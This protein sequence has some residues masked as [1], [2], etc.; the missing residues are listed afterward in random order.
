MATRYISSPGVQISETDR[1]LLVSTELGT[2]VFMTGF[3]AQGPT[4]EVTQIGSVSEYESIFG[5]P[6]N[7]QER[8]LYHSA[9]QVLTQSP[10]RLLITRIPY[11][12]GE[13]DGYASSYSALV[14]PVSATLNGSGTKNNWIATSNYTSSPVAVL[15]YVAAFTDVITGGAGSLGTDYFTSIGITSSTS[16]AY[17][18]NINSLYRNYPTLTVFTSSGESPNITAS[19]SS[20]YVT[21][22]TYEEADAFTILKPSSVILTDAQYEYI[23]SGGL[24]WSDRYTISEVNAYSEIAKGG[25]VVL[26]PSKLA[27][28]SL[29][30][31]YYLAVADNSNNG[32]STNFD[33]ITGIQAANS[34]NG[35]KQFYTDI[36]TSRLNFALSADYRSPKNSIS[37]SIERLPNGFDFG[38]T[39]YNDSLTF[40]LYKIRTSIYGNTVSLDYRIDTPIVGS[41]YANK[42]QNNPL[43]GSPVAFSLDKV[44]EATRG[45]I[46]IHVNPFI[47]SRGT[48]VNENGSP[49]K[50]VRV[51]NSAKNLYS[52]GVFVSNTNDTLNDIGNLPAKV[53]RNLTRL[54]DLD[55]D[56]DI[57]TECGLGTIWAGAK[58]N[59]RSKPELTQYYFDE[60]Y[61]VSVAALS[62][63]QDPYSAGSAYV[64]GVSNLRDAYLSIANLFYE[65]AE[66]QERRDHMFIL[67]PLRYIF[68][69]GPNTKVST[70]IG[71][72]FSKEVYNALKNLHGGIPSQYG[73]SYANWIRN[74]DVS[75]DQL[76]WLPSSGYVAADIAFSSAVSFPWSAPAG[77]T[78]GVLRNVID[79]AINPTQ[80]QRDYLY[81]INQNPIAF[82]PGDGYVIFGQ[83]TMFNQPSAFDRIN[84][85]RLFLTL[86]KATKRLLK[87]FIFE[88]NSFS[89]R[90]R[91]VNALSP[92]FEQAKNN[93]GVYDYRI[94][95]D[96]RNNTP[97]V[98][99]NNELK[100]AIYIQP[101]RTAEFILAE[102]IGTRTGVN[103][104]ELV[105]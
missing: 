1:T 67:D 18:N 61:P 46:K 33:A 88:P 102:F 38:Q 68:V 94:I 82:F 47:S 31:G 13:G 32:P 104:N 60:N 22:V 92:I 30:E 86:E 100:V 44:S 87:F 76:V 69:N 96:E 36:P 91:L 75:S 12:P 34:N 65:T 10:A 85:R 37:E 77:F 72:D 42:T 19:V 81:K 78:R 97:D 103:L 70:K 15:N 25:I 53:S 51:A 23:V 8:Y 89:T 20:F 93:D 35:F 52:H 9:R 55:I 79:L 39:T 27:V 56:V 28:N 41:L 63:L 2:T 29:Y 95:C 84:V 71:Y 24:D 50:I 17:V 105:P 74:N 101:T 98:I 4:D 6:T 14:Y 26:N 62:A 5:T 64:E 43:G 11:G 16:A 73:A 21:T 3:A 58:N 90:V 59:P 54:R 83:K 57:T 80:K 49:A 40:A 99:D 48:W 45:Q 7:A 66:A